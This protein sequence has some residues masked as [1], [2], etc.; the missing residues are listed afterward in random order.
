MEQ[1]KSSSNMKVEQKTSNPVINIILN[2]VA[3]GKQALVFVGTR[4][5]A[6]KAAEEI[7]AKLKL[8]GSKLHDLSEDALHSLPRPTKQCERLSR[9]IIGGTAFHHSGIVSKQRQLVEDSFRSGDIKVICCTPTLAAGVDLPAFRVIIRDL[10]RFSERT[11]FG[12]GGSEWIPVLEYLQMCGRAGRPRFDTEGQ[13]ILLAESETEESELTEHYINGEP[14]QIFSKLAVEPVLR[15]YLLSLISTRFVG[16]RPEIMKFFSNTFWAHQYK[17]LRQL[18]KTID[19][20]LHLLQ[21]WDFIK[22]SESE[23]FASADEIGKGNVSA[24]LVGNRVAE[25]YIDPL[26]AHTLILGMERALARQEDDLKFGFLQLISST[27]ELRPLLR[28]KVK[29]M[30]DYQSLTAEHNGTLL[31]DE[32]SMFEEGFEEFLATIKTAS[33][34]SDWIEE[35]DE[36]D[37]MEKYGIRPG[38]VHSKREN[39]DWILYSAAEI[40]K[41]LGLK[42]LLKHLSKLRYRIQNGVKEELIPLLQLKGIGRVRARKL[43][44]NRI[45]DISDVRK[46]ELSTLS[47][48][49]GSMKIAAD[50]KEQLG[51]KVTVPVKEGKRKGQISLADYPKK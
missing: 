43:F 33:F 22:Q 19:K 8:T 26:T 17:D 47:Q 2:T 24:T 27:L 39:A 45:K 7:A 25:L 44:D 18:E 4:Q 21:E 14:E 5:G 29:E 16:S 34:F 23:E 15:T 38:E 48:I 50:L 9:C 37:L 32:P 40:A 46:A 12:Y 49:I 30:E 51:E 28:V 6:E 36:E 3:L 11:N 13:A 42:Q 1:Q 31:Q 41:L 10:K 35:K 20:I